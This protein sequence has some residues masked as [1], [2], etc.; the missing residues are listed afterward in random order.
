MVMGTAVGIIS[1]YFGGFLDNILM[2]FTDGMLAIPIFFL[3]L[4]AMTVFS[5]SL[6]SIV[7]FIGLSRWMAPARVIR[8]EVLKSKSEEFVMAAVA[9]GARKRRILLRHLLPQALPSMLVAA[10]FGIAEAILV[11]SAMS[12]LG[13]G[14]QPPVPSWGNML[15]DAQTFIY[16][17][18]L[19]AIYPGLL[20]FIT[21]LAYNSVGDSLCD[22]LDPY[23]ISR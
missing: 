8:S 3:L 16:I 4:T 6:F 22:V 13:L 14:I 9:I 12:Y 18:P 15:F 21:V 17:A 2:R 5:R 10:T 11:E 19:L 23:A 20:I 7:V 1:G